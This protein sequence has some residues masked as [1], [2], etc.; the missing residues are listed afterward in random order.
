M[1]GWILEQFKLDPEFPFSFFKTTDQQQFLHVHDCLELNIVEHGE[2]HYI[3]NGKRYPICKGDIFVIN[4]REPHMAVHDAE[5]SLTVLVFDI[6][7]L[8]SNKGISQ[9]LTPFL[10]RKQKFSHRITM[11]NSHYAEMAELFERIAI[12]QERKEAGWQ[13][14][15]QSLLMY[16]L[17]QVYRCY[18]EKQE[19]EDGREDFQRM[20][21]RICVIFEY[22]EKHFTEKITLEQL[23]QEVSMS[24]HYLC[25]C[26][27]KVTGRTLFAYV[28]QMRVQYACYL[29]RTTQDSIMDLALESGFN[30]VSYFNRIFKKYKGCTPKEYRNQGAVS[31]NL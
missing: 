2:G 31:D 14:A 16:L 18:E 30:T 3:I 8:W 12:E 25:K 11:K 24:P 5:L 1:T 13:I 28:E 10:S 17:T 6:N 19:L 21:A 20:Y 29:L 23:A 15:I 27:K 9:F 4:N 7:L 22:I 26:F